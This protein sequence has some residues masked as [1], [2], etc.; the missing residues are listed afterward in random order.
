[1]IKNSYN[2]IYN[3]KIE[4]KQKQ[5]KLIFKGSN[6]TNKAKEACKYFHINQ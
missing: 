4:I 3:K 2:H 1:M 6:L 5:L